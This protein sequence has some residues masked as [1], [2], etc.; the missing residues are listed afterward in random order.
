MERVERLTG[1]H[2]VR[3][4]LR[5]ERRRLHRLLVR[6]G[7]AQPARA[8]LAEILALARAAGVP[9]AE[10]AR[11][12]RPREPGDVVLL[13]AGP[14]PELSLEELLEES[15]E[16]MLALD[17]VEDPQNLGAL[18]RV[19]EAAGVQ[20][21]LLQ[22]RRSPPLSPAAS[23]ASAGALEH[24][25]VARVPNLIRSLKLLKSKG[26]W[27]TAAHQHAAGDLFEAS[28][29]ALSGRLVLLLGAEGRGLRRQVLDCAD[30]RVR[31]P[32]LGQVGS[33]NVAT[34][35]AVLLFERLRQRGLAG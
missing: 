28:S 25:R 31:I 17:G 34:A 16:A 26:F 32:M 8:E 4:A 21:L 23:R 29:Q 10:E 6:E 12:G 9:V 11:G 3:E 19:A 27:V 5:A 33:L 35:A 20:A 22:R 24:L 14:L 2:P 18:C 1:V 15:P 30:Y 13:E 7:A